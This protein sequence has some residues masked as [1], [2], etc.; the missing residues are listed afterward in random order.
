MAFERSI[1]FGERT[2]PAARGAACAPRGTRAGFTLIEVL[3]AVVILLL[4]VLAMGRIY[5]S[6]T[7][8]YQETMKQAE[9]D[10]AARAVMDYIAREI[11][12]AMF[13]NPNTSTN[14]LLTMRYR[15]NT[16]TGNYGLEGADEIWFVSANNNL[17]TN[18]PRDCVM[19]AYFVQ[20][21]NGLSNAPANAQYRFALWRDFQNVAYAT[22]S[23]GIDWNVYVNDQDGLDW[24]GSGASFPTRSRDDLLL[25]NVRT[26]EIFAYEDPF[27]TRV[28][29]WDSRNPQPLFCMDIYLETFGEADAIRAALLAAS[30]GPGDARTVEFAESAVRRHYQRIFFPLKAGYYDSSYP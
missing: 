4:I 24:S 12:L 1:R 8:A 26:F 7:K 17:R 23:S 16:M 19:R 3:A 20:N 21:Y 6:T 14:A 22:N 13:D 11:G 9:R 27:G 15:A 18:Q 30:L 10:A 5:A 2:R 28:L 29:S 25:E